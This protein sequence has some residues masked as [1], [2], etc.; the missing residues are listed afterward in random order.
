M[1]RDGIMWNVGEQTFGQ[2]VKTRR[3]GMELSQRRAAQLSGV[4]EATWRNIERGHEQRRGV[5]R[6][7][8]TKPQPI[9]VRR[10]AKLLKWPVA[11]AMQWAG[12]DDAGATEPE[13][14]TG[15][16]REELSQLLDLLTD[17]QV[18]AL[19]TL[20]ES[21]TTD[22]A[23]ALDTD[24]GVDEDPP[25]PVSIQKVRR[26]IGEDDTLGNRMKKTRHTKT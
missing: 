24:V 4:G 1:L 19:I 16:L 2:R 6:N 11:D 7:R 20:I 25:R 12:Y 17:D 9:T 14:V 10:I 3:E 13:G 26:G 8:R 5:N 18:R 21:F 22:E 15:Y 23:H